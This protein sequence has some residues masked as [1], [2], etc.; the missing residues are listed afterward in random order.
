MAGQQQPKRG[1]RRW[2]LLPVEARLY[3]LDEGV[4]GQR[5]SPLEASPGEHERSA[6]GGLD[7]ELGQ[8]AGLADPG[9]TREERHPAPTGCGVRDVREQR[10]QLLVTADARRRRSG[11]PGGGG[12]TR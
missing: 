8:Q 5:S 3:R 10:G 11:R 2:W 4:V 7:G 9:L 1:G 6:A 12:G